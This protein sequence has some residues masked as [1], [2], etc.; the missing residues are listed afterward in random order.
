[1]PGA[2]PAPAPP[3]AAG[4]TKKQPQ[5]QPFVFVPLGEMGAANNNSSTA[6]A[7]GGLDGP[8]MT[9]HCGALE[10]LAHAWLTLAADMGA[11]P[12]TEEEDDVPTAGAV[13]LRLQRAEKALLGHLAAAFRVVL[14]PP[15]SLVVAVAGEAGKGGEGGEGPLSVRGFSDVDDE[16]AAPWFFMVQ[17]IPMTTLPTNT[18]ILSI[19]PSTYPYPTTKVNE[20]ALK[21]CLRAFLVLGRADEAER[22]AARLVMLPFVDLNFTQVGIFFVFECIPHCMRCFSLDRGVPVVCC[23]PRTTYTPTPNSPPP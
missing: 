20:P 22:Q 7:T 8:V 13:G 17:S 14:C 5:P 2:P 21:H 23:W 19:H 12:A 3:A 15:G 6:T 4:T 11:F 16:G 10:R 9:A 1:M 18:T